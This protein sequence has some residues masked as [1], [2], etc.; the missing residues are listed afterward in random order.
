[1]L[2][3]FTYFIVSEL[4]KPRCSRDLTAINSAMKKW[5]LL[6]EIP[7]LLEKQKKKKDKISLTSEE[8]PVYIED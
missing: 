5:P 2:L 3:Y 1:M 6:R 8:N 7:I 4:N